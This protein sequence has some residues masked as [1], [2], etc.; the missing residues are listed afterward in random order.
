[1][2]ENQT[3]YRLPLKKIILETVNLPIVHFRSLL[4]IGLPL[5]ICGLA[6]QFFPGW[7][8]A[9]D[10]GNLNDLKLT[11][12]FAGAAMF[13]LLALFL[14]FLLSAV[15]SCH[16][17][18]TIGEDSLNSKRFG[19][20]NG[21]E[22][23]F[24]WRA[25]LLALATIAISALIICLVIALLMLTPFPIENYSNLKINVSSAYLFAKFVTAPSSY[26]WH[27]L[28]VL[29]SLPALYVGARWTLSF[30]AAAVSDQRGK[31][32]SYA[33]ALSDCNSWRVVLLA[34]VCPILVGY[35]LKSFEPSDLPFA[36]LIYGAAW[37]TFGTVQIGFSSLCYRYL[38]QNVVLSETETGRRTAQRKLYKAPLLVLL[39]VIGVIA[40]TAIYDVKTTKKHNTASSK[41]THKVSVDFSDDE[42]VYLVCKASL[43]GTCYVG[44]ADPDSDLPHS[45]S[46]TELCDSFKEYYTLAVGE[47]KEYPK[48][49]KRFK[50]RSSSKPLV[51][52][53]TCAFTH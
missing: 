9:L 45:L 13:I 43:S 38:S 10:A 17:L 30:P 23:S 42:K 49:R 18:F 11:V 22:L 19:F 32:F 40:A 5:I 25:I 44:L 48:S 4:R 28:S 8:L 29:I 34:G 50:Y 7:N 39:A 47:K 27:A 12:T 15:V 52:V 1:M 33:W 26:W 51:D 53:E 31:R 3:E 37:L 16:R 46:D 6:L 20:W 24:I 36:K 35:L 21:T 2:K 14:I 41:G